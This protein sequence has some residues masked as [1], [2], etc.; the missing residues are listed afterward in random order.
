MS[1]V[2]VV[3]LDGLTFGLVKPWMEAGELPVLESL[4]RS[5][6]SGVLDSSIP[7]ISACSWASFATGLDP[8]STRIFDFLKRRLDGPVPIP[9]FALLEDDVRTTVLWGKGTPFYLGFL[10]G[11]SVLVVGG[12]AVAARRHPEAQRH[13]GGGIALE[14]DLLE[15]VVEVEEGLDL[16]PGFG[17]EADVD[18]HAPGIDPIAAI[19]ERKVADLSPVIRFP[20]WHL[21]R[22]ISVRLDGTVPMCRADIGSRYFRQIFQDIGDE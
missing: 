1:K 17:L 4:M 7:P 11:G 9:D 18:T 21:K 5:G 14:E 22:D 20:C 8:G 10:A 6:A 15:R 13:G 2:V 16:V 3:G 12:I 19:P